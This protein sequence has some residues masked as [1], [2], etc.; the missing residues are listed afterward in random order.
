VYDN[1]K[2][3]DKKQYA[4]CFDCFTRMDAKDKY[5]IVISALGNDTHANHT[6]VDSE[7]FKEYASDKHWKHN[8]KTVAEEIWNTMCVSGV[9]VVEKKSGFYVSQTYD[10][11]VN[12][13]VGDHWNILTWSVEGSC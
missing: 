11:R 1:I 9:H 3:K 4:Q 12:L 8:A 6:V 10:D 7:K 5:D 13:T 2:E